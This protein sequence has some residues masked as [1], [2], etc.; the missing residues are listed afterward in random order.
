M[1][2]FHIICEAF[3]EGR[4]SISITPPPKRIMNMSPEKGLFSKENSSS[5]HQVSGEIFSF[6]QATSNCN[7]LQL[8]FF[9]TAKGCQAP[10]RLP[11]GTIGLF[12][13]VC[14]FLGLHVYQ[15]PD[16][17]FGGCLYQK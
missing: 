16:H 6:C 15:G 2:R 11:V 8:K 1:G 9:S 14:F 7:L 10:S 13:L 3:F 5:N 12:D 17:F 4:H